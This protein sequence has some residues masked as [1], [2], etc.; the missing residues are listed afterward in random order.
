MFTFEQLLQYRQEFPVIIAESSGQLGNNSR[1]WRMVEEVPVNF[2]YDKSG[3]LLGALGK[4]EVMGFVEI[5]IARFA[6]DGLGAIVKIFRFEGLWPTFIEIR[7]VSRE[8]AR[9]FH[10]VELGVAIALAHSEQFHQLPGVVFVGPAWHIH[11]A[12]QINQHSRAFTYFQGE[13]AE[14]TKSILV[15]EAVIVPHIIVTAHEDPLSNEV[16]VPE[17]RHFCPNALCEHFAHPAAAQFLAVRVYQAVVAGVIVGRVIGPDWRIKRRQAGS[18]IEQLIHQFV[19]T[20]L[21]ALLDFRISSTE[22]QPAVQVRHTAGIP[23]FVCRRRKR[24]ERLIQWRPRAF[25]NRVLRGREISIHGHKIVL[26]WCKEY[27]FAKV[28]P[29]T[30]ANPTQNEVQRENYPFLYEI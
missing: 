5:E 28:A 12:V 26:I 22:A 4:D 3:G 24:I 6:E 25:R 14:I 30:A 16:V 23:G 1:V 8:G 9:H 7:L 27:A 17:Q 2:A 18:S 11:I 20:F 21:Q 15:Q 10:N 13:L 29:S 19:R